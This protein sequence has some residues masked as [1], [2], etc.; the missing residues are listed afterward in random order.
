M[1]LK[2]ACYI[3]ARSVLWQTPNP[4]DINDIIDTD[5]IERLSQKFY[6]IA[7]WHVESVELLE[8]DPDIITKAVLYLANVHAIPPM[9]ED[10]KWFDERLHVLVEL[11]CPNAIPA[12]EAS[13]ILDDIQAGINYIKKHMEETEE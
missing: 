12:E 3:A 7:L 2:D 11:A 4:Q 10:T 1:T 5:Q 13:Q 9:K 8:G 6:E